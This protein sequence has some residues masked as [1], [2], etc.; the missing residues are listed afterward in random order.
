MKTFGILFMLMFAAA[1]TPTKGYS[2][3]KTSS[4]E[5]HS[6]KVYIDSSRLHFSDEGIFLNTHQGQWGKISHIFHDSYG[7]YLTPISSKGN[8]KNTTENEEQTWPCPDC[9][10]I[11]SKDTHICEVCDWPWG[12]NIWNF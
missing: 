11:N 2:N 10:H 8:P 6:E 3:L 1:F 5:N 4:L 9:G 7:Y 12:I